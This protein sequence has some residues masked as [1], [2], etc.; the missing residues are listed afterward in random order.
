L[1]NRPIAAEGRRA[2]RSTNRHIQQELALIPLGRAAAATSPRLSCRARSATTIGRRWQWNVRLKFFNHPS[3]A[4]PKLTWRNSRL[5]CLLRGKGRNLG[6]AI[7]VASIETGRGGLAAVVVEV[8]PS[9]VSGQ[10]SRW[11]LIPETVAA[12]ASFL[13]EPQARSPG[14]KKRQNA[15]TDQGNESAESWIARRLLA[16]ASLKSR[17]TEVPGLLR[18]ALIV[19][20][21]RDCLTRCCE[22]HWLSRARPYGG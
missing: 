12:M 18:V 21:P 16:V 11:V 13:A 5:P 19:R 6:I 20:I 8:R 2:L 15:K 14:S 7:G 3:R 10:S 1:T 17:S 4:V 22:D 9:S